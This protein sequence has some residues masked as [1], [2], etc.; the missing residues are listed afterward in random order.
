MGVMAGLQR[1]DEMGFRTS[2]HRVEGNGRGTSGI[3]RKNFALEERNS[4][5]KR[6]E[7]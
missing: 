2:R 5:S 1:C 4:K 6:E 7:R 3:Y